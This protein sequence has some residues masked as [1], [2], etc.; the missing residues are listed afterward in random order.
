MF[1]RCGAM[2]REGL[3]SMGLSDGRDEGGRED[4]LVAG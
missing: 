2:V 3:L 4:K 1:V